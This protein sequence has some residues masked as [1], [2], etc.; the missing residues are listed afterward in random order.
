MTL[1]RARDP[2]DAGHAARSVVEEGELRVVERAGDERGVVGARRAAE[3]LQL[4]SVLVAPEVRDER[5]VRCATASRDQRR[6]GVRGEL[7][8]DLPVL[9]AHLLGPCGVAP[10][11]PREVAD[12]HDRRRRRTARRRSRR[13]C[14]ARAR[15]RRATPSRVARRSRRPRRRPRGASRPRG[16]P[17]P[18]R[19]R[20]RGSTASIA[21][22]ART[23]TPARR[24][25]SVTQR[26]TSSPTTG[27]SGT[28]SASSIV[29][30]SPRAAAVEATSAPMNPA[31]TTT[32][33]PSL[34]ERVELG[35]Q[36]EALVHRADD[37]DARRPL[38]ARA[39]TSAC[40]P[41]AS[42]TASPASTP[43]VLERA[44]RR[45]AT[46]REVAAT[47][48]T[49]VDPERRERVGASRG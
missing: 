49:S 5:D 3:H 42:T 48:A 43:A 30:T 33:R 47:P 20:D 38:G 34:A 6:R 26:P 24:C 19:R 21:T 11:E 27:P 41:V 44:P 8:G 9:D 23:S 39:A 45:P 29:T 15:S 40:A 17:P 18:C 35:A 10:R 16:R 13:R 28:S 2:E 22:P 46:S 1:S 25:S 7:G 37:V 4:A 12:R 36:R 32:T 31:P 14:R